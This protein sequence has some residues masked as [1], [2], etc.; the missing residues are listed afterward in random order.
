[1][2]WSSVI[3]GGLFVYLVVNILSYVYD[4]LTEAGSK[5]S[6]INE[7]TKQ[8]VISHKKLKSKDNS[9]SYSYSIWIYISDWNYRYGEKKIIFTMQ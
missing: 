2:R 9:T 7:A 4:L 5:L 8:E 6:G 1:M 3:L